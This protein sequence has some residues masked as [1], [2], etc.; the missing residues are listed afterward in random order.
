[1]NSDS[2]RRSNRTN[3]G[4]PPE[5]LGQWV[6]D[7][8]FSHQIQQNSGDREQAPTQPNQPSTSRV[9]TVMEAQL[10]AGNGNNSASSG[11]TA[12]TSNRSNMS[13]ARRRILAE[14]KKSQE[15]AKLR[16][17]ARECEEAE[18]RAR[19]DRE[20]AEARVRRE[21]EAEARAVQEP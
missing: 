7:G 4:V 16:A 10:Q 15:L 9:P 13:A 19:R 6:Q 20:E 8:N 5:R 12:Q 17:D 2:V 21:C 14:L 18:E 1:M 3:Q 11:E